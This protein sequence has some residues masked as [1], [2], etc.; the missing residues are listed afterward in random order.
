[1]SGLADPITLAG[2][3][4][5]IPALGVGTWAWGDR[6]TWGMGGYDAAL[7]EGTIPEAFEAS[8]D[9]GATFFDTAEVYGS[10]RSEQIIG[11]I[12]AADP[13]RAA[14]V[15]IATKFMPMPWKLDVR[16][17]LMASLRASLDLFDA[18]GMEALRAKSRVLTGYLEFLL[19]EWMP[20]DC[21]IITP[22]DPGARGCQLSILVVPRDGSAPRERFK[23]LEAHGVVCDFREPNVVRV[24]PVPLY[25]GFHEAWRFAQILANRPR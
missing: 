24:A 1:M 9:G 12:L 16:R 23:A 13:E 5:T 18:V 4:V 3:E 22:S 19:R 8:V 17:S 7:D 10:G 25:N 2:S 6:S 11:Q 14:K 21:R 15:Q 20:D